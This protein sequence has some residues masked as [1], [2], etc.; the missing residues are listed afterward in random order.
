MK[1]AALLA[2][3]LISGLSFAAPL[4][5][6]ANDSLDAYSA[7]TNEEI[8][9][10]TSLLTYLEH[11]LTTSSAGFDPFE[12][13]NFLEMIH[14]LKHYPNSLSFNLY[15]VIRITSDFY[16]KNWI[17]SKQIQIKRKF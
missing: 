1:N 17:L 9:R 15:K 12:D 5:S 3:I 14:S 6:E 2:L 13:V 8:K 4:F 11:A 7:I 10:A 16:K